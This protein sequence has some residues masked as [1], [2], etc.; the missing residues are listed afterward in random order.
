MVKR[1]G[2]PICIILPNENISVFRVTGMKIFGRVDTYY[3]FHYYFFSAEM[4]FKMHK[5]KYFP[6]N[7]KKHT[8]VS[9]VNLARV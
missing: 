7:L 9:S 4:P 8:L 3:F 6:E 2:L 5:I 1:P